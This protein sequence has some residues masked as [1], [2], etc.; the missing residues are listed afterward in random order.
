MR[1]PILAA[2]AIAG[3]SAAAAPALAQTVEQLTVTGQWNGR[4]EPPAT[5]S[6]IVSYDDL[7][8]RLAADQSVLRR[9]IEVTAREICDELGQDRPNRTNLGRSCQ[10]MAVNN[11]M[12]QV[13]FAVAQSFSTPGP[14][15]AVVA[16]T[17]EG[18]DTAY[19]APVGPSSS[20]DDTATSADTAA[21]PA[22][23]TTQTVTNGP[24]PD[25][26]ENRA[27]YGGPMSNAGKHTG[28][29]GN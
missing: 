26:A 17:G 3:L 20:S 25:T 11:A 29:R 7:D 5:L 27:R 14:A 16:P 24:V 21:A 28:A 13:R 22:S 23:Y 1:N 12:Q 6:R 19:V 10:D 2:L 4:G 18:A 8:L 9:R 15:Y